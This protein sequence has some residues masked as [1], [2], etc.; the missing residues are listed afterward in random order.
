MCIVR[1]YSNID[2]FCLD[3]ES[4]GENVKEIKKCNRQKQLK[5]RA[6]QSQDP[7]LY[8]IYKFIESRF[9]FSNL[10][11]NCFNKERKSKG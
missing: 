5:E 11:Y 10:C 6:L 8:E 1:T 9:P 7:Y 4:K 3:C 2:V